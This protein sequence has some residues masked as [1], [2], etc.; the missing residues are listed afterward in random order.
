[1]KRN[2]RSNS[3]EAAEGEY[4]QD[5]S[6]DVYVY[7]TPE[8]G[9]GQPAIAAWLKDYREGRRL[10]DDL[11]NQSAFRSSLWAYCLKLTGDY[12]EAKDLM[13]EVL[14]RLAEIPATLRELEDVDHLF[15][16]VFTITKNKWIDGFRKRERRVKLADDPVEEYGSLCSDDMGPEMDYAIRQWFS[17]LSPRTQKIVRLKFREDLT[18]RE[19]AKLVGCSHTVV[20][21]ELRDSYASLRDLIR[22]IGRRD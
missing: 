16:L 17:R 5:T 8:Q 9:S 15:G 20:A 21:R 2:G 6:E 7:E 11:L 18:T 19:I 3:Q 12:E 14:S 1:M 4:L 10:V 22:T 13:Q